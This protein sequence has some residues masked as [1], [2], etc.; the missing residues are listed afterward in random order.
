MSLESTIE[1]I[2]FFKGEPMT[3]KRLSELLS[4]SEDEIHRSLKSLEESL[5]G[6]GIVLMR[7][8]DSVSLATAPGVSRVIEQITK[9]ELTRDI[10]KA[11][12]EVLSIV[13]YRG[14][15]SR[16]EVD[17]IRGVNSTFIIRNLLIRGLIEKTDSK[18]GERGFVY[19]PTL[20]LLS[21]LGIKN[22]EELPEY[23]DFRKELE[24]FKAKDE[25]K[26]NGLQ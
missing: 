25:N 23:T 17:Y 21:Y 4:V 3:I 24:D 11:G 19:K 13:L 22:K 2:L 9:D 14:P 5:D 26:E 8:E 12:L 18:G 16:R 7:E 15:I 6:R 1:A 20:E 10:G